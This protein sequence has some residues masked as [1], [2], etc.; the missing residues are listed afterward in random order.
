MSVGR[1]SRAMLF[2]VSTHTPTCSDEIA[3]ITPISSSVRKSL[4]FSTAS[5]TLCLATTGSA[6]RSEARACSA[7]AA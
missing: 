3:F 6:R 1:S 4:W 7:N 2:P 5:V